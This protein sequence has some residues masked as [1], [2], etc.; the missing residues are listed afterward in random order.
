M[1][2]NYLDNF[3][4]AYLDNILIY[5]NNKLKHKEHVHKVLIRLY[6]TRLQVNIKK[7]EFSVKCTKYLEF[8]I[9]IDSIETDLEKTSIINQ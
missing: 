1:L 3:C 8:I 7:S 6:N 4:L 5:S 2:L 9:S